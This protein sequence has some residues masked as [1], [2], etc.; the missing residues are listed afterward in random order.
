MKIKVMMVSIS[1]FI[2]FSAFLAK[3]SFNGNAPG[4]D[5]SG[6]HTFQNGI[7]SA[8]IL[9]NLQIQVTVTGVQSGKEVAGELVNGNGGVVDFIDKTSTNP[10]VLTAP[11]A[12]TYRINAGFKDPSR[13][14]DSTTVN[15]T[16]T[17]LDIPTPSNTRSTFELYPNHPNPFN[18]ETIIKFS[19]PKSAKVKIQ[20]FTINGQLIRHLVQGRFPA[21]IHSFR[22]DGRDD[23][24]TLVSSG[25]YLYQINSG[26]NLIVRRM[27][28]SK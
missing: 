24:G 10:F 7:V 22:W 26:E 12:G 13:L 11:Q 4:C 3:P 8:T 9:N 15:L 14:W 1:V 2:M 21:G 16:T 23:R 19:L 18:N 25:V 17:K 28:F 6:C 5:G 27:T 20:I